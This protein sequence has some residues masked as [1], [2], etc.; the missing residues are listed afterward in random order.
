[1]KNIL[2]ISIMFL[3]SFQMQAQNNF[4]TQE[5]YKLKNKLQVIFMEYGDQPVTDMEF[6]INTG[7][8][9]EI[10]G[11]QSV[12]NLTSQCLLLGNVV[13]SRE[14]QDSLKYVMGASLSTGS[15]DNYSTLSMQFLNKDE[16]KAVDLL[17][18][19]LLKPS[20]PKD[21]VAQTVGE[22]VTYNTPSRMNPD[23][24]ASVFTR[25]YVF[26]AGS[27][28]GRHFYKD[29]LLK[30]SSDQIREFYKFNYTPKN[31]ILVV[32][33]KPDKEKLKA[34][35][36]KNF[37][38]WEAAY[39]EVNG[40][41]LAQPE[42]D[43]KEY[44]FVNRDNGT[45]S[46]LFWSK[47]APDVNSKDYQAFELANN[48]FTILLFKEIREKEGK[49]YG[50]QS[51]FSA[52]NNNGIYTVATSVRNEVLFNTTESFDGVLKEFYEKGAP[53]EMLTIAKNQLKTRFNVIEQ[54]S[55]IIE[56]FNP[57]LYPDFE[58]RKQYIM[59]IDKVDL[60]RVNKIIKKYYEPGS[61]KLIIAGNEADLK[62]QLSKFNG[63]VT[64]PLK[65]IEVDDLK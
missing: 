40:V 39:S 50:I 38:G 36:E 64:L 24:L 61:Y 4:P 37:G 57:I 31:C 47:K 5:K 43:K 26:G 21:E 7:K 51:M 28:L 52:Q 53:E 25:F 29:Q 62:P 12:A 55:Q 35:I 2:I 63:L 33:G 9:N 42:F 22:I 19:I 32:S 44:V 59:D 30:I 14:Q 34:L 20:F 48:V 11:M 58:K 65:A 60:A 41:S 17:S 27:P 16:D 1:M 15:N 3:L 10:P 45:Q 54:P 6:Y 8:K 23:A 13:Y 49:T 56:E 46:A 18:N